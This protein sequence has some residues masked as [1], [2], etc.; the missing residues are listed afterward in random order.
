MYGKAL[1]MVAIAAGSAGI[2]MAAAP[3]SD[4]AAPQAIA[5]VRPIYPLEAQRAKLAGCARLT[6]DVSAAGKPENIHVAASK[7]Y[8]SFGQAAGKAL[9]QWRFTPAT[10]KGAPLA[11]PGMSQLFS[12]APPGAAAS[13]HGPDCGP[14]TAVS[15]VAATG[16]VAPPEAPVSI[17]KYT[18][19]REVQAGAAGEPPAAPQTRV[20]LNVTRPPVVQTF[21]VSEGSGHLPKGRVTV[22]FCVN[23]EGNTEA[24]KIVRSTPRGLFDQ[25]ALNVIHAA[26]FAPH[27]QN[28][29]RVTACGITQ[30]IVFEPTRREG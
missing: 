7:P 2:A 22:R 25:T 21:S 24:A 14:G 4:V 26:Q 9:A 3:A 12:F 5:M 28:G 8:A 18:P 30:T 20:M 13:G 6:F 15:A 29:M 19:A 17:P 23:P 16:A 10:R 27:V 1:A 11:Y